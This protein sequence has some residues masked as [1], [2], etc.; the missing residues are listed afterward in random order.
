MRPSLVHGIVKQVM[1]VILLA[2]HPNRL[3]LLVKIAIE[4]VLARFVA[5]CF[6]LLIYIDIDFL[7]VSCE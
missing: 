2:T 3:V 1:Y 4:I 5:T 6:R 7:Q